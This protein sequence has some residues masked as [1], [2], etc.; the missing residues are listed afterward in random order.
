MC[1][2]ISIVCQFLIIQLGQT[3]RPTPALSQV[4]PNN[5]LELPCYIV[6]GYPIHCLLTA[7]HLGAMWI[8]C[9]RITPHL[10]GSADIVP[11]LPRA[12]RRQCLCSAPGSA[13]TL[14]GVPPNNVPGQPRDIVRGYLRQ[15]RGSL[16]C[17]P[18]LNW[19]S[20]IPFTFK[21]IP[22]SNRMMEQM[23]IIQTGTD[24]LYSL[25]SAT[26]IHTTGS[27]KTLPS[28]GKCHIDLSVTVQCSVE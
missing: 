14:Y 24:Q 27:S 9:T 21:C 2:Y 4:T 5:V 10:G 13:E 6:R 1:Q 28:T 7:P 15:C 20:F 22:V 17:L 12:V 11:E 8:H 18:R 19:E 25:C 16:F 26:Y 23:R 3:K